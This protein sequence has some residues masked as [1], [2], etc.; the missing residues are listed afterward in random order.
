M[1][2]LIKYVFEQGY[3]PFIGNYQDIDT[4]EDVLRNFGTKEVGLILEEIQNKY[5]LDALVEIANEVVRELKD[6]KE[7]QTA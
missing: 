2:R 5:D 6:K 7:A 3:N 1:R 4:I